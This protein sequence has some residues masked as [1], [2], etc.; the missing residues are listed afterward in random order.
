VNQAA[1]AREKGPS[2]S[3]SPAQVNVSV[4]CGVS[5]LVATPTGS[6]T[7]SPGTTASATTDSG[8]KNQVREF[9]CCCC[10]WFVVVCLLLVVH[11]VD[12]FPFSYSH[13]E[14]LALFFVCWFCH[15]PCMVNSSVTK[16]KQK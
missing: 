11:L 10:C 14:I 9:C 8:D 12:L 13:T 7:A 1:G 6:Q 16:F 3:V 4:A 2:P 5:V 15:D